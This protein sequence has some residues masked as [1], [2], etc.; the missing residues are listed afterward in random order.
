MIKAFST[1]VEENMNFENKPLRK[2]MLKQK[3]VNLALM[4]IL[5]HLPLSPFCRKIRLVLAEKSL[6]VELLEEPVWQKRSEFLK[7]NPASKVPVLVD[8]NLVLTESGAIFEY[9]EEVFDWDIPRKYFDI[10]NSSKMEH[11]GTSL[12]EKYIRI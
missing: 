11:L 8:E 1:S 4:L 2:L 3:A 7:L 12:E 6:K 5:Y 10:L 9:I